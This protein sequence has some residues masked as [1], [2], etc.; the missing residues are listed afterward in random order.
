M[1]QA[2]ARPRPD[3]CGRPTP[4]GWLPRG[5]FCILERGHPIKVRYTPKLKKRRVVQGHL[6]LTGRWWPI[7]KCNAEFE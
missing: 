7:G 5:L 4:A 3:Q 1:A 2:L 6:D